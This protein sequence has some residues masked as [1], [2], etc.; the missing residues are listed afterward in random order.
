MQ[1]VRIK[2]IDFLKGIA[3]ILVVWGHA[4]QHLCS[5]PGDDAV[6]NLIY[7]FHVPLFMFLSGFV[8][9]KLSNNLSDIK[10][11]AYQLLT[12]FFFFPIVKGLSL[13]GQ[14]SVSQWVENIQTPDSGLWFLYILFY[15]S[16]FFILVNVIGRK[17]VGGKIES[18][19]LL[20][21]VISS[22]LAF[23]LFF[24]IAL[25]LRKT[26]GG[27]IDYGTSLFA[28][29]IIF[30]GIGMYSKAKFEK[31]RNILTNTWVVYFPL[32]IVFG[33]FW[34]MR[35]SPSF[36][37]NPNIVVDTLYEYTTAFLGIAMMFSICI[38]FISQN[39]EGPFIKL[40][41]YLGTI[42]LGIY[43]FYISIVQDVLFGYMDKFSFNYTL[44]IILATIVSLLL[45][46]A[47]VNMI[48]RCNI[49]SQLL[50]GKVRY[51]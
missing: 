36:I 24:A 29:H 34:R 18:H 17:Y 35:E 10:K 49:L 44:T 27:R 50:L 20:L 32:W 12:P 2:S 15:I 3:I 33:L 51:Q 47:F 31:I 14:F 13:D 19:L 48:E 11:R 5:N 28:R 8:S 25:L 45:S 42:T 39:S 9:Y 43:A 37:E 21:Y 23:F 30:F 26:Y 22:L 16:S 41:S 1:S 46:V 7:S 40:V 38:R 6:F 4:I